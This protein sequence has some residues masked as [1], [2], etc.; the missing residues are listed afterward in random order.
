[1]NIRSNVIIV[2]ALFTVAAS[3][4]YAADSVQENG[5]RPPRPS[6]EEVDSD[7]DGEIDF[8]EFSLQELPHGDHQT[9]FAEID[10]DS[11]GVISNQ[12]YSDHKPPRPQKR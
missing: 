8:D 1:M 6:F 10:T 12:E 7:S 5:K 11:D 3:Q 9:V 2:L 4:T